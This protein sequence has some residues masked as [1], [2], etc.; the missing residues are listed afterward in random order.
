M[1]TSDVVVAWHR[2]Q[3]EPNTVE[4]EASE[5]KKAPRIYWGRSTIEGKTR[6]A[7]DVWLDEAHEPLT[8][9]GERMENPAQALADAFAKAA[10]KLNEAA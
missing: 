7:V 6:Y 10:V 4:R 2:Q 8:I 3:Q 9:V 5:A 1:R